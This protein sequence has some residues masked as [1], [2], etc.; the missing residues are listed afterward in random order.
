MPVGLSDQ[1]LR[2]LL[3]VAGVVEEDVAGP[4]LPWALLGHLRA[5]VPCDTLQ[6]T[7]QD[8]PARG[9][10][11]SQ[12]LPSDD[13]PGPAQPDP[14]VDAYWAHYWDSSCCSYPDRTGDLRS[15][16]MISDFYSEREW[17]GTGMYTDYLKG[18][19][20]EHEIMVCLPAGPG[21]TLRFLFARGSGSDFDERDRAVLSL[22]RPHLHAAYLA[23]ERRRLGVSPLT[24]RQREIMEY[25]A[26][27]FSN[28][29]IARRTG[30]SEATVRK[31]LENVF[32]RL[33]V[34]SRTAAVGRSG[35]LPFWG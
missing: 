22:L 1:D 10:F 23:A 2:G 18:V 7:G 28:V 34:T 8:T 19:D 32:Q 14:Q 31:H 15:V 5:L 24:Q 29:Q 35:V 16:T 12:A 25:V 17:H 3:D 13:Q 11:A 30:V 27:G 20:V 4:V 9:E 6:V 33:N 21:R 26:A